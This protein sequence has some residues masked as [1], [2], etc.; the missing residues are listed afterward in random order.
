MLLTIDIGNTHTTLGLFQGE[1]LTTE[2]RASTHPARTADEL[3][4][5]LHTLMTQRAHAPTGL[6][7]LTGA[8]IS[9]VVP[10]ATGPYE[11]ALQEWAQLT[12]LTVTPALKTLPIRYAD[13]HQVGPDRLVNAVA[14]YHRWGRAVIVVDLGTA[15]T[16]D[17]V[18]AEGEFMGGAI[19]PGVHTCADA[20]GARGARLSRVELKAPPAAIGTTTAHNI[21]SGLIYGYADLIDGLARRM[22]AELGGEALIVATGGLSALIAPHSAEIQEVRPHLTLEGLRV[23]YDQN[24]RPAPP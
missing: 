21:Q 14:A 8:I 23:I 18:S 19:F 4:A 15:T 5:L 9:S 3:G 22:R 24:T 2:W 10:S 20:L 7:A 16:L 17:V 12:P 11:R 1:A 6:K 13:P